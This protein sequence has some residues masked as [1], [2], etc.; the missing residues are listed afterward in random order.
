[1]SSPPTTFIAQ[2]L[3]ALAQSVLNSVRI[4]ALTSTCSGSR[5]IKVNLPSRSS[6]RSPLLNNCTT[7]CILAPSFR[8]SS[9]SRTATRQVLLAVLRWCADSRRYEARA[10]SAFSLPI[11]VVCHTRIA[12]FI[13]ESRAV[14]CPDCLGAARQGHSGQLLLHRRSVQSGAGRRAT[15]IQSVSRFY[16]WLARNRSEFYSGMAGV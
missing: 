16:Q 6:A 4:Q 13:D 14:A 5:V 9:L 1:M 3:G 15:H 8:L 10:L 11:N 12:S 7:T 2:R